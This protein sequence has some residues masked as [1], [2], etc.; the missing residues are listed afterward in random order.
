MLTA[1]YT[2][3]SNIKSMLKNPYTGNVVEVCRACN[4]K[5]ST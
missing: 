3:L 1:L 5:F 2:S 4:V